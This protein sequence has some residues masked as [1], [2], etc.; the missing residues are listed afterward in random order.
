MIDALKQKKIAVLAG[1]LSKERAVSLRSGQNVLSALIRLGYKAELLDTATQL[2]QITDYELCFN[3]LH[4][5]FGEDGSIQSL[6]NRLGIPYVG[7]NVEA[8][9]LA[10]NK[11]YT[12]HL[13]THNDIPTPPFLSTS[14]VLKQLPQ[15]FSYP[16]I[17]KPALGGSSVDVYV[18]DTD[19]MLQEHTQR[20]AS[21]YD[22]YLVESFIEGREVTV[23][24][25]DHPK[26]LAL[27]ILEL[28]T[29]NRFYDYEAKYTP[30]F[31]EFILPAEL[32]ESVAVHL[33]S[34]AVRVHQ[35]MG[36]SGM[37]RVDMR[38]DNDLNPYVLEVNTLP[39]MTDLSDLPAQ[40]K[41]HGLA[42]D[43]LVEILLVSAIS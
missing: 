9:V 17:V 12:K 2:H 38:L 25:I 3:V 5:E 37:S 27:P 26:P 23:G 20:L 8:S 34:I 29:K 13:L 35:L 24:V 4:G 14:E 7:S 43:E 42:F 36:C 30:G 19:D 39:G 18:C 28:V 16:V 21:H 31:T 32:P 11:L 15:P 41:A 40:A 22:V 33:K 6:L 10:M 1:G